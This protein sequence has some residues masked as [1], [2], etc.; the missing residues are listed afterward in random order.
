MAYKRPLWSNNVYWA[1]L[2]SIFEALQQCGHSSMNWPQLLF[3]TQ[4]GQSPHR[5]RSCYIVFP[6][7]I[8]QPFPRPCL[9][10]TVHRQQ[11]NSHT[12]WRGY[13]PSISPTG[14]I[15]CREQLS[16]TRLPLFDWQE[17]LRTFSTVFLIPKLFLTVFSTM[18][19]ELWRGSQ[20]CIAIFLQSQ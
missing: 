4:K 12:G 20:E 13:K 11:L 19:P 3:P 2:Q 17:P 9:E 6:T 14:I 7:Y 10:L 15:F 18:V 8:P 1:A 16:A 5:M